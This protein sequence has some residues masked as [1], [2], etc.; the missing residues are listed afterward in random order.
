MGEDTWHDAHRP[1][2]SHDP[3][4]GHPRSRRYRDRYRITE[5]APLGGPPES[6]T[7]KIDA[8]RA[9]A[10]LHQARALN[11]ARSERPEIRPER[12]MRIGRWLYR[13]STL[14]R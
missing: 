12:A 1:T 9:R 5:D 4:R 14:Q 7:Q 6:A 10:T 3:A 13:V 8:T 2:T 11:E